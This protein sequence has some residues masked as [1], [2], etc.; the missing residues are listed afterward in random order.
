[1]PSESL[2][3]ALTLYRSNTLGLEEAAAY[4]NTSTTKFV[5]AL[6]SRGIPVRESG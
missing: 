6:R 5:A 2:T 3:I 1:M 4:G